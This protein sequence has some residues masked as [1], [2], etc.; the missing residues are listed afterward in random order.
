MLHLQNLALTVCEMEVLMAQSDVQKSLID[1]TY[2][3]VYWGPGLS[4]KASSID[5][6]ASVYRNQNPAKNFSTV[7]SHP[8]SNTPSNVVVE[9]NEVCCSLL[10][11]RETDS[12]MIE[13]YKVYSP[14]CSLFQDPYRKAFIVGVDAVVLVFDSQYER[15]EANI[16][17]LEE[18]EGH[19]AAEGRTLRSVAHVIQYTKRDLPNALPISELE[20]QLNLYS[21]SIFMACSPGEDTVIDA[22]AHCI[23]LLSVKLGSMSK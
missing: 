13:L 12:G 3:V 6:I 14:P 19:L 16:E 4:G 15:M 7:L 20:E 8:S 11:K 21:A 1:K 22:F 5:K 9:E 10:L 2:R 23:G 17:F 18:L